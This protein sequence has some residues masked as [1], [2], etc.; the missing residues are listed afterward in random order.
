MSG[1]STSRRRLPSWRRLV[2]IGVGIAVVAA[3]FAYF[4]PQI[5]SYPDVWD[6]VEGLSWQ[7]IVALAAATVL[8]VATFA[9]PWMVA[10]PGLAF[11]QA[12]VMT[13]ASTALSIVVPGG[14][15][16]GMAGS[17]AMLRSWGFAGAPVGRAVTLAGVWNQ[18]ANLTFPIVGLFILN[19]EGETH[20]L[21]STAAFVGVA[22][23]GVVAAGLVLVLYSEGLA[24][25]IGEVTVRVV[26]WAKARLRRRAP[27]RFTPESFV[28]FR[29]E[30]V[31]LLRRR[32]LALTLATLAGHLTVFLVLVVSL[33]ALDVSA[34]EVS[35]GEA[36]AGWSLV[37]LLGAIPIT[38]GGFGII[39]LGLTGALVAFG[40]TNAGV[41]AAVL[42]YRFLTVVPTLV[43]GLLAAATW[44]HHD[45]EAG[46]EA[47]DP[48]DG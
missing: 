26:G 38:P 1:A 30:T 44:R 22:V 18:L 31:D 10:L 42:V 23:V 34:E 14:A 45:P 15:A 7:W 35:L 21:L 13:Q 25:D 2:A 16:V 19:I 47:A 32:W 11:R 33:R 41:V 27:V 12:L 36:F 9:P 6:V 4:L 3:T 5:A 39:E 24:R 37:R 40:G 48:P 8:N 20:A 29:N 43:L 46:G 28:G 17:F